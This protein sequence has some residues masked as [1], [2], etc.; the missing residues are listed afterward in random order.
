MRRV[1][2]GAA[3][4]LA[5]AVTELAGAGRWWGRRRV[6]GRAP[7]PVVVE[8]RGGAAGDA[9][10]LMLA[11]AEN[12][13]R[14]PVNHPGEFRGEGF[15][16]LSVAELLGKVADWYGIRGMCRRRRPIRF[17]RFRMMERAYRAWCDPEGGCGAVRVQELQHGCERAAYDERGGLL[18]ELNRLRGHAL[19]EDLK[20]AAA[21]YTTG[22][23]LAGLTLVPLVEWLVRHLW[24]HRP[25]R[26]WLQ[27]K[28]AA[29]GPQMMYL[30]LCRVRDEP[31][32]T[33]DQWLTDAFLADIDAYY[34]LGRRLNRSRL[35]LLLMPHAEPGTAS[36]ALLR[37]LRHGQ[38]GE[39][40]PRRSCPVVVAHTGAGPGEE[41]AVVEAVVSGAR[42]GRTVFE[43][44]GSEEAEAAGRQL[45]LSGGGPVATALSGAAV[46]GLLAA[47]LVMGPTVA[48]GLDCGQGVSLRPKLAA[49]DGQCIGVSDGASA[50]AF[51][52][53]LAKVSRG[54]EKE[55]DRA[56]RTGLYATVALMLPMTPATEPEKRQVANEVKGAYL[57]QY[58]ANHSRKWG[59]LRPAIRLVLA[60][61]GRDYAHWRPV[62]DTLVA[63]SR[64]P[65]EHLRAVTGFNLSVDSTGLA[66]H[67]LTA[68]QGIPVVGGPLT[69][70]DLS[71]E[72]GEKERERYPGM[73]RIVPTNTEQATA[74]VRYGRATS[75]GDSVLVV[76]GRPGD[77]YNASLA[78]AFRKAVTI[79]TKNRVFTSPGPE[80]PGD[81]A[82]QFAQMLPAVCDT[83]ARNIYFAGRPLHLRIFLSAMAQSPCA[84]Q[85]YKVITGSG[86]S[87]VALQLDGKDWQDLDARDSRNR[88]KVVVQ[89]AAPGHPDAW[90]DRGL[91]G[92]ARAFYAPAGQEMTRLERLNSELGEDMGGAVRWTDSRAMTSHDSVY[93]AVQEI[94]KAYRTGSDAVPSLAAVA[95]QGANLYSVNGVAGSTGMIC[96]DNNGSPYNKAVAVVSLDPASRDVRFD[97]LAWPMRKPSTNCEVLTGTSPP[98]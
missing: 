61:P 94:K 17:R 22:A 30:A 39:P 25:A 44:P 28:L 2:S 98:L 21:L 10:A 14:L 32:E 1:W 41:V 74:L 9:L 56:E 4:V 72:P 65:G 6:R 66:L 68:G 24:V 31:R 93:T 83:G 15:R 54:I 67:S 40:V 87:T 34:H 48:G 12:G 84:R 13:G 95:R 64:D 60:N 53:G 50:D 36:G 49:E 38:V 79:P 19:Q 70:D 51:L 8:L 91:T 86:A 37:H 52:P 43:L 90:R 63:M 81:T 80:E 57:A 96:L 92:A 7:E 46:L 76:D 71:N 33:W 47:G 55:N 35:P 73:V 23:V 45:D 16:A 75:A 42:S 78:A 26:T 29:P 88:L 3:G 77:T 89:Y 82:D 5:E 58:E 11:L 62:T 20:G 27:R 85:N 18:N 59:A 97:A 69:A